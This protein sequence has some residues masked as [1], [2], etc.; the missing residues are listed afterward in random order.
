MTPMQT[1]A[2]ARLKRSPTGLPIG[3]Y[4]EDA[5]NG[6]EP[7]V[8]K[9]GAAYIRESS[10]EQGEGFSPG[11]QRQKI[12]EWAQ[13]AGIEMVAE[14]CDLHSAWRKSNARPEF[15]RLMADAA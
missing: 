1:Q 5:T 6:L 7:I 12:Y 3:G 8:S 10:E 11:A 14:Y 2:T 9:R 4:A 15:Q 13:S